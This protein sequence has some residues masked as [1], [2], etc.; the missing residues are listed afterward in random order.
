ML[1][2]LQRTHNCEEIIR[3]REPQ[4]MLR[5]RKRQFRWLVLSLLGN[6]PSRDYNQEGTEQ[7][8]NRD[9]AALS[10]SPFSHASPLL[11]TSGFF[12]T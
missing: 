8:Q 12:V 7:Q 11:V 5:Q 3:S 4:Q 1:E 2:F 10:R 6:A 9:C